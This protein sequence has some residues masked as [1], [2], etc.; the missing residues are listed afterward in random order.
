MKAIA[1]ER[2][3]SLADGIREALEIYA[4]GV[5]YAEQGKRLVWEDENT[6]GIIPGD[7]GKDDGSWCRPPLQAGNRRS[8]HI[9]PVP[10]TGVMTGQ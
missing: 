4:I 3:T 5:A 2:N 1:E 7:R 10:L 6:A 9:S 8:R